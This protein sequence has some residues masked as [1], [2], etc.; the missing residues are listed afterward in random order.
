MIQ[1]I[2]LQ[3]VGCVV[4]L[5]SLGKEIKRQRAARGLTQEQLAKIAMVSRPTIA[6]LETDRATDL[7]YRTVLR[8]L[9]VIGLDLRLTTY[10]RRRP[11]LEDLIA[12]RDDD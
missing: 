12:S 4:D 9:N 7:G 8:I 3:L 1:A 11:T 6:R 5:G 10:N 2:S